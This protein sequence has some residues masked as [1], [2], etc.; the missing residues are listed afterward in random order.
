[1]IE[2][3]IIILIIGSVV[4]FCSLIAYIEPLIGTHLT[5]QIIAFLLVIIGVLLIKYSK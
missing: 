1:M 4:S 3:G 2:V 5:I